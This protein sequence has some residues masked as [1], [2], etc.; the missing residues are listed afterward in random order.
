MPITVTPRADPQ[1]GITLL[2]PK[3][4]IDQTLLY[5]SILITLFLGNIQ[6]LDLFLDLLGARTDLVLQTE[7]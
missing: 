7:A 3:L 1:L 2:M 4:V 6:P 5:L